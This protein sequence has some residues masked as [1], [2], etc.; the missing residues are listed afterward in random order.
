M[1]KVFVA[2]ITSFDW[3]TRFDWQDGSLFVS[4]SEAMS[5]ILERLAYSTCG[6]LL[7]R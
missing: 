2:T 4:C 5:D 1:P 7:T 3:I 6:P